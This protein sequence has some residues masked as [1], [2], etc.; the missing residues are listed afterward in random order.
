MNL[1]NKIVYLWRI[2]QDFEEKEEVYMRRIVLFSGVSLDGYIAG[3]DDNLDWLTDFG[4]NDSEAGDDFGKFERTVDTALMGNGT[5]NFIVQA[6]IDDP[7]PNMDTYVFSRV[8]K[9]SMGPVKCVSGDLIEFAESLKEQ[10]GKDIWLVGGGSI[11]GL[12]LKY[13]MI[14]QLH[15]DVIPM[16]I[17]GGTKL[18]E[19]EDGLNGLDSITFEGDNTLPGFNLVKTTPHPSGRV[20]LIYKKQ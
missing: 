13:G 17:G 14:D 2:E 3:E 8:A 6:G 4:A 5:Y 7:Y 15:L 12:F 10:D 18:F 11:N 9:A 19:G 20:T 1:V 16:T